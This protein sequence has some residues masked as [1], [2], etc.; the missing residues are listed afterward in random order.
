M[1]PRLLH[2]GIEP[3]V[4]IGSLEF[5]LFGVSRGVKQ[6]CTLAP[7]LFNLFVSY[8]TKLL[9]AQVGPDCGIHINYCVDRSLSDLQK[10]KARG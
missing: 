10:F 5:G 3:R 7:V 2:D 4:K 8:I 6:G 9:V 1:L